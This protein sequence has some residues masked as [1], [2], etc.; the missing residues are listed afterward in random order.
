MEFAAEHKEQLRLW[1][2]SQ[3]SGTFRIRCFQC[4]D[5]RKRANQKV[6]TLNVTVDQEHAV[7]RC[8]HCEAQGAVRLVDLDKPFVP[9]KPKPKIGVVRHLDTRLDALALAFLKGRAISPE[10]AKRYGC[11]SALAYFPDKRREMS[12]IAVPYVID[13]RLMGNKIRAVEDKALVCDASLTALCGLQNV[14]MDASADFI[15]CEGELDMLSCAEAGIANPTSVPNGAS[16]F[17]RDDKTDD[18]ST[19]AFLWTAKAKIDKA[20]RVI[21]ATD[22]D[23]PGEKLAE[24]LAR[25]IGKHKCWKVSYPDDCK[26]ANDVLVKHGKQAL[27]DMIAK[28][29]PWPIEGLYEAT[30]Y[31]PAMME[32]YENGPGERIL[33][34]LGPV[35]DL[36]SVAPG[37]LTVIT[38]IP[39]HGKSTFTDQLM[40]NLARKYDH[41]FAICS[42]ENP[43]HVHLAKIAEMLLQKHFF[44]DEVG[45][46]MSRTELES[47]LPF[48]TDHF[49][50][51]NQD[52][53]KKAT[54]DSIIERIKTAVFR[55]GIHGAVVDPYNYIARPKNMDRET[56]W[57]DDM[58]TQLR[59]L[60]QFHG[61]HLWLVAHPT[62][63]PMLEDGTYKPPRG[64]SISGSNAW[65]A[66]ADFGLTVHKDA[67]RAGL[68][69]LI[70]WKTRFDW[71]GR[72][73]DCSI[74]YDTQSNTYLTSGIND[75][76]PYAPDNVTSFPGGKVPTY[77]RA[78]GRYAE[79]DEE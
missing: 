13:A 79:E 31:V 22:A 76:H 15:I 73:G 10:T 20:K 33:P 14:D 3:G 47:V 72:E 18:R 41:A 50:F 49:K 5:D 35:D 74:L 55:W 70:N 36:Y 56:E 61:I 65:Y 7:Y 8:W 32:L 25:R 57:I 63:L 1:A 67:E 68:V 40:V 46:K 42:F 45:E 43:I 30:L 69:H 2:R 6:R 16:S 4:A 54:L 71:L 37:L 21:L 52:D 23:D 26:D 58:L 39:G 9:A 59:L 77:R 75:M 34:G 11:V 19:M 66:K 60:A 62:K 12:G 28:V 29:E 17:V 38:G 48:I 24:E 64:Y 44:E 78:K 27:V 51:L 53:G